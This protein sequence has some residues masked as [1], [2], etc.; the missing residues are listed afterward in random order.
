MKILVG[1]KRV[2]DYNVQVRAKADGSAVELEN[3]KMAINPFDEVAVEAAVRLKEAGLAT[4]IIVVSIGPEKAQE[5]LRQALAMGADRAILV[6]HAGTT[7]PLSVAKTFK[8]LAEQEG[9]GLVMLGKQ[10]I[11]DD[12][13]QTGQMLAALL[14]WPQGTFASSLTVSGEQIEVTREVDG[15]L[16]TVAL[17]L[18]AVIT[19]DLRLHEPRFAS[20]PAIMKAKKKPLDSISAESLGVDLTPRLEL[21]GVVEPPVRTT[22]SV[23]VANAAELVEKLKH[24]AAIA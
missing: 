3:V 8:A 9:A 14:G 24:D 21:L 15:G 5:T 6:P 10:A 16:E 2:I 18:P 13:N 4:E 19:A 1:V 11:D 22:G 7:E 12:C 17:Q 23:L 20:L